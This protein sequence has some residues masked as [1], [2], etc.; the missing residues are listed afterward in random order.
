[1]TVFRECDSI[2]SLSLGTG[3]GEGPPCCGATKSV[4][5]APAIS[6]VNCNCHRASAKLPL[7]REPCVTSP[8]SATA[9]KSTN[10]NKLL[11]THPDNSRRLRV[12]FTARKRGPARCCASLLYCRFAIE[13]VVQVIPNGIR[14]RPFQ[15]AM[16][17]SG[18]Q[19]ACVLL[20]SGKGELRSSRFGRLMQFGAGGAM[21]LLVQ[22]VG[23]PRSLAAGCNHLVTSRSGGLYAQSSLDA[24][25]AGEKSSSFSIDLAYNVP[26]S[27][28]RNRPEPCSGPGCSS[29][30]PVPVRQLPR[31]RM[32]LTNG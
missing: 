11:K 4:R 5:P 27:Q 26:Q 23:V 15:Y 8:A 6:P 21:L 1:M 17:E 10:A 19:A 30:Q 16:F 9:A 20:A 12:A 25:V 2:F 14:Q 31:S 24:I 3:R 13:Y 22:T 28:N 18:H 29:R 32:V 7:S